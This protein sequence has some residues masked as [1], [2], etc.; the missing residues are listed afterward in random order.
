MAKAFTYVRAHR[1][2]GDLME[3]HNLHDAPWHNTRISNPWTVFINGMIV[4]L[5]FW[6]RDKAE[7]WITDRAD[8][9]QGVTNYGP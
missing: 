1:K 7:K 8:Y 6:E 9:S 3:L 4:G 2:N 5:H